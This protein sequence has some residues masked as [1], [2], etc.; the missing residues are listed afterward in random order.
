MFHFKGGRPLQYSTDSEEL[1]KVEGSQC[2]SSA[3]L[4]DSANIMIENAEKA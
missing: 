4:T 3:V 2:L 1:G